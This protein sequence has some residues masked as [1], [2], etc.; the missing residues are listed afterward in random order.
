M[1]DIF[2]V[3]NVKFFPI[4]V[5]KKAHLLWIK[6]KNCPLLIAIAMYLPEIHVAP[7]LAKS[8]VPPPFYRLLNF[9]WIFYWFR[10]YY[11]KNDT[12]IFDGTENLKARTKF[13]K[14]RKFQNNYLLYYLYLIV[15]YYL[16]LQAIDILCHWVYGNPSKDPSWLM[17]QLYSL[18]NF[19]SSIY[20]LLEISNTL[21]RVGGD[22]TGCLILSV[23]QKPALVRC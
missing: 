12:E 21:L 7:L 5:L 10:R 1:V 2:L 6:I 16:T 8:I 11:K 18:H 20:L 15:G 22:F 13:E 9:K 4:T 19:L 14:N 17:R 23:W 3:R